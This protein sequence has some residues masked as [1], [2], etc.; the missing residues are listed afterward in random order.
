MHFPYRLNH[1]LFV[2]KL[3][4]VKL[5]LNTDDSAVVLF[6]TDFPRF[7]QMKFRYLV[8]LFLTFERIKIRNVGISGKLILLQEVTGGTAVAQWLMYC[9]TVGDRGS[10][11]VKVLRYSRG[12][13]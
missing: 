5:Y 7:I 10:T 1:V 6:L 11:V 8:T 12:P 4:A 13:R 2:P 3:M 9:A